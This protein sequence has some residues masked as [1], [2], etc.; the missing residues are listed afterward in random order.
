VTAVTRSDRRCDE[1]HNLA[2]PLP[3]FEVDPLAGFPSKARSGVF[4][5][6]A[7]DGPATTNEDLPMRK[8]IA[9]I[10]LAALAAG[11]SKETKIT[12]EEARDALPRAEAL[13]IDTPE[14]TGARSGQ[15]I[16]A[17]A[18]GGLAEPTAAEFKPGFWSSSEY[19]RWTYFTAWTVNGGAWWTLTLLRFVTIF[20]PTQC[21]D[22]SCTWGPWDEKSALTPG[23]EIK[24][25]KLVVTKVDDGHF[26]YVLSA[27]N[28]VEPQGF[29]PIVSGVAFPKNPWQG[30]GEFKI[31][32][33][34]ARQLPEPKEDYGVLTIAYDN[35]N[36]LSVDASLVGGRSV[37]DGAHINAAYAF[38]ATAAGGE[39][40]VAFETRDDVSAI[41]R[42]S[43]RSRWDATG[44][45]RGDARVYLTD[46]PWTLVGEASECW[47]SRVGGFDLTYDT[48]PVVAGSCPV[49][50]ETPLYSD[51]V[52]P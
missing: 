41:D 40:Q 43:L 18:V 22:A 33:D 50:L 23:L 4:I 51:L 29:L 38:D 19:A 35:E 5:P 31:N 9:V 52:V 39:L 12:A 15:A 25:W 6:D 42:V 46:S 47:D 26:T 8:T 11:C 10:A 7:P 34:N 17:M 49:G 20:P 24:R 14:D 48:D 3:F 30:H 45:G 2:H 13:Q 27:E 1:R 28:A 16:Q 36:A 44:A 37:E 21:D 32:F